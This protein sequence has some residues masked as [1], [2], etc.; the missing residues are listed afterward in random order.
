M[1]PLQSAEIAPL[2]G[3]NAAVAKQRGQKKVKRVSHQDIAREA[4]VS[5]VTVSLVLAG[6]DQT[7]EETR[8]RV[9]EVARR[10]RYRP[11]LLVRGMQTGRTNAGGVVMPSPLHFHSPTA[12]GTH[13]EL[14]PHGTVPVQPR[15]GPATE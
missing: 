15:R 1:K 4:N 14:V 7:S 9:M 12:R 8:K 3:Y 5:R 10:L 13:D 2:D 11:N 6:K